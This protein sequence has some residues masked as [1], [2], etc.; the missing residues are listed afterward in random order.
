VV[1]AAVAGALR[2]LLAERGE[3]L[4]EVTITVPVAVLQ[5]ATGGELGNQIG[6][7]P[8]T[9]PATGYFGARVTRAA[10]TAYTSLW[11]GT[12]GR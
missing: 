4:G 7:M 8:V 12:L 3:H 9:V 5:A 11:I 1:L 10:E 6:I 2:T